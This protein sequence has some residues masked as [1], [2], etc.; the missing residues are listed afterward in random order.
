MSGVVVNAAL[1]VVTT[2]AIAISAGGRHSRRFSLHDAPPTSLT[3]IHTKRKIPEERGPSLS[4]FRAGTPRRARGPKK[5]LSSVWDEALPCFCAHAPAFPRHD[6][7]H[8]PVFSP[9]G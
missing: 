3:A 4:F 7:F 1:S 6:H 2:G 9:P 8:P 5:A